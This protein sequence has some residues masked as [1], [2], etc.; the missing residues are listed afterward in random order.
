LK[1]PRSSKRA[2]TVSKAFDALDKFSYGDKG[3]AAIDAAKE[4]RKIF[5]AAS[6][7]LEGQAKAGNGTKQ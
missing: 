2:A 3:K 1:W 4:A 6:L 5:V 7:K